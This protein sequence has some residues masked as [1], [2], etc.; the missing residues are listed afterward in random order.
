M[1]LKHFFGFLFCAI[2]LFLGYSLWVFSALQKIDY[3]LEINTRFKRADLD[4]W[5]A[6][7]RSSNLISRWQENRTWQTP[8]QDIR[9]SVIN[10]CILSENPCV[11]MLE[12]IAPA[13]IFWKTGSDLLIE[14]NQVLNELTKALKSG[15]L[16]DRLG[17]KIASAEQLITA[18]QEEHIMLEKS[19]QNL[20]WHYSY[21]GGLYNVWNYTPMALFTVLHYS[22][23]IST[24]PQWI[25][26]PLNKAISS[27]VTSHYQQIKEETKQVV[28][29]KTYRIF[30]WLVE[31]RVN[32][33][34]EKMKKKGE[35][36]SYIHDYSPYYRKLSYDFD[37]EVKNI[38]EELRRLIQRNEALQEIIL[39][40]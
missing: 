16:K 17:N 19:F 3:T 23:L 2:L 35:K 36:H 22:H 40:S 32:R 11:S 34:F 7:Q 13:R 38:Y 8:Q 20:S 18:L 27:Y 33:T 25:K 21:F 12:K 5:F 9:P 1:K 28:K 31:H 6:P 39:S 26:D 29:K 30:H 37:L 24:L 15:K 14:R 10:E 4:D